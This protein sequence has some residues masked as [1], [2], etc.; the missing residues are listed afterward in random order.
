MF[1]S[2]VEKGQ[3]PE[4][5]APVEWDCTADLSSYFGIGRSL[6]DAIKAQYGISL[7]KDDRAAAKG[8]RWPDD[9]TPAQRESMMRYAFEDARH[10]WNL[11]RD[12]GDTWPAKEKLLS[13]LTRKRCLEGVAVDTAGILKDQLTLETVMREAKDGIPWSGDGVILSHVRLRDYCQ[14]RGVPAAASPAED[15][16]E[17][18]KWQKLYG[19][20]HPV[21][22]NI[23][24]YRKANILHKKL[25]AMLNRTMDNG[26]MNFGLKY[27]GAHTGRWSGAGGVNLQNLP[28]DPAFG[29]DLR[30][31]FVAA[32]GKKFVICD[33]AQIEPRV[34]AW[35]CRDTAML[36]AMRQGYGIYEAFAL[37]TGVWKGEKGTLKSTNK[38]LYALCKAQVLALGYGCGA[39]KFVYMSKQYADLEITA[40]QAKV[41]VDDFRYRNPKIT[42]FWNRLECKMEECAAR[43]GVFVIELP[44]GRRLRYPA[45]AKFNTLLAR[46]GYTGERE[47]FWGG[48]LMEN[49]IQATARDIL[50]EG[51]VRLEAAGIPVVFSAHDEVVCQV[52][53]DFIGAEVKRLMTIAP[54]WMK[55]LP[56]E[57][58]YVES[59]YYLK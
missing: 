46:L 4:S 2:A 33:L 48:K 58:E 40:E 23:R 31:K 17:C 27:F 15:N 52:D 41:I 3:I 29:I 1:R 54:D 22:G 53:G 44:S 50:A 20:Q 59:K 28:R 10:C 51:I 26:R 18:A 7:S 42:S 37:T 56:L 25:G 14:Q 8:K 5:V 30:A 36:E 13:R 21:V 6:K 49:V 39:E 19:A 55:D 43:D 35:V 24:R 32:D 11:W 12:L 16:E 9:F 57:A 47:S 34:T 45:V 38:D